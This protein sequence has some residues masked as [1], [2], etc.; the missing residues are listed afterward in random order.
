MEGGARP[1]GE[2]AVQSLE[3][4]GALARLQGIEPDDADLAAVREFLSV[5]L[6]AAAGLSQGLPPET[7]IPAPF[8]PDA[9]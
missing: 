5:F 7:G 6:P 8:P 3:E 1:S 4:L 2:G 9:P